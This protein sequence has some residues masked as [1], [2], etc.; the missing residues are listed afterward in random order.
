MEFNLKKLWDLNNLRSDI[1][2][3]LSL[4]TF[5]TFVAPLRKRTAKNWIILSLWTAYLNA[6]L[7][8]NYA[9]GIIFHSQSDTSVAVNNRDLQAF[10]ATFLLVHLGGPDTITALALEDNEIGVRYLLVL[11]TQFM[12]AAYVFIRTFHI[13]KL[14]MP[15][16]LVFV[17]GMI[18]YYERT[19]SLYLASL[20]NLRESMRGCPDS[21][22]ETADLPLY[23]EEIVVAEGITVML[24]N[25]T[26]SRDGDLTELALMQHAYYFL[27]IIKVMIVDSFLSFTVPIYSRDF[28]LTRSAEDA[29]RM[30][31]LELNLIYEFLYTKVSVVHCKSGYT[32][33]FVSFISVVVAL[34]LFYSVNK[35]G[36]PRLDV[37]IT[38]V[39]LLGAIALDLIAITMLVFSNWAIIA[40]IMIP[41]AMSD[42]NSFYAKML[43]FLLSIKKA[44]RISYSANRRPDRTLRLIRRFLYPAGWSESV[45][46]F[47]LINYCI[48]HVQNGCK[49]L[50]IF[51]VLPA[52]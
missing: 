43:T 12:A 40:L 50:S 9:A 52:F 32:C 17:A 22:D 42:D 7:V 11:I 46:Q 18:K 23:T 37:G 25:A 1:I 30:I 36:F 10:W 28:F 20:G 16:M 34:A 2:L 15:T 26:A 6:N 49:N 13:S 5:L 27:N 38:Y 33:K 3:S 51:S 24:K 48:Q 47:N 21:G 45:S 41:R 44:R 14:W 31:E 35:Q 8:V 29:F 19:R 4:L 39:L